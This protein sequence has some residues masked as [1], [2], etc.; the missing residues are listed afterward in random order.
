MGQTNEIK[1]AISKVLHWDPRDFDI[2]RV[3]TRAGRPV[4]E[5][6]RHD[7]PRGNCYSFTAFDED[8]IADLHEIV[9]NVN[10]EVKS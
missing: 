7:S 10:N 9:R 3:G 8:D 4:W 2:W 6:E 1:I 5:V